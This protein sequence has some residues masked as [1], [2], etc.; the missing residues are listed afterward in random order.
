M[1]DA[2]RKEGRAATTNPKLEDT[3]AIARTLRVRRKSER[4]GGPGRGSDAARALERYQSCV[5]R[6]RTTHLQ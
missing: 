3:M 2:T 6:H 1:A 4:F 5:S